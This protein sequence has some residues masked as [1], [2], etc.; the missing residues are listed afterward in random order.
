MEKLQ[1]LLALLQQIMQCQTK[2]STEYKNLV[3]QLPELYKND[4]HKLMQ[5]GAYMIVGL[6]FAR[7][8][9]EGKL[10]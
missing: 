1:E 2:T 5:N 7:R 9:N 10:I 8:A 3:S 6:Q 4:Y